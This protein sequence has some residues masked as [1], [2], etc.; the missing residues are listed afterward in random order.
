VVFGPCAGAALYRRELFAEIGLFDEDFFAYLEDVDLA[1]RARW[2]GWQAVFVPGALVYHAHSA[3][4]REGSPFKVRLLSKNKILL[5]VK[6]YPMPYLLLY[7]PWI[8]AYELLSLGYAVLHY[9]ELSALRGR[10]AALR[11]LPR[12]LAK[13]RALQAGPHLPPREIFLGLAPAVWPWQA[14]G[15]VLPALRRAA[16]G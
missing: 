8:T 7:L 6:N 4:G 14:Y 12:A 5:L 13:R 2:R 1:W 3:T 10:L 16:G 11:L 15:R 9:R